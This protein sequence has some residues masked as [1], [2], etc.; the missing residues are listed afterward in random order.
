MSVDDHLLGPVRGHL[1][2]GEGLTSQ[3]EG[4]GEDAPLAL[5]AE[6]LNLSVV[7]IHDTL[8]QG[9]AHADARAVAQVGMLRLVE[10]VEDVGLVLLVDTATV[11]RHLD[12]HLAVSL[13]HGEGY[14]ATI[15]RIFEGVG[16]QVVDHLLQLLGIKPYGY[17]VVALVELEVYL[18]LGGILAEEEVVLVEEIHEVSQG[19]SA[20]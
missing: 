20:I 11:V 8:G 9:Q 10:A 6:E 1:V 12:N 19:S 18:L 5:L 4:E 14:L 2:V 7:Q 17:Q 15:L 3:G 16:E 13:A